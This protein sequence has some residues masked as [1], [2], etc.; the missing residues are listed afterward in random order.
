MEAKNLY[1]KLSDKEIL[2]EIKVTLPVAKN[3]LFKRGVDLQLEKIERKFTFNVDL[4][5]D[6]KAKQSDKK[7]V[8]IRIVIAKLNGEIIRYYRRGNF[9]E[10]HD[11]RKDKYTYK[12]LRPLASIAK[13]PAAVILGHL[14][15]EPKSFIYC[16]KEYEKDGKR[17]KNAY[18]LQ[19]YGVK[20]CSKGMFPPIITFA[21]SLNLPLRY[22]LS[23][24]HKLTKSTLIKLYKDF[25]LFERKDSS[26][27][28]L[29]NG[30]SFGFAQA[31]PMQ[32]HR[33]I[34]E[35][36]AILYGKNTK[37]PYFIQSATISRR[38]PNS[39]ESKLILIQYSQMQ[40]QKN[41]NIRHYL[42]EESARKFVKSVLSAPVYKE[43]GTLRSLKNIKNVK[44]LLA[45]SGTQE[46]SD[47]KN[48]KD[49]WVVGSMII[50]REIYSFVVLIGTRYEDKNGLIKTIRHS[51][52]M[53]PIVREV[54]K[55][56]NEK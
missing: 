9:L 31:T 28:L 56:L 41:V 10:E 18:K 53:T 54:V 44:F 48:T 24:R 15:D 12:A 5:P 29:I 47:G 23:E 3:Y 38:D 1:N 21:A 6:E 45:K 40:K 55:S 42:K 51:Q 26:P 39:N 13:I 35:L 16:N 17:F 14:R 46:T 37:E 27:E 33:I 7:Q 30:L 20:N 11:G 50:N 32:A 36:T 22:A 8:Q 25:G 4:F 2:T 49:K 52:L 34:H 43:G 19:E